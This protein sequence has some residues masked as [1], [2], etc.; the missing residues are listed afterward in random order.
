MC[1]KT[2]TYLTSRNTTGFSLILV[3]SPLRE[4]HALSPT[5]N[6][7]AKLI[8]CLII[9]PN[10]TVAESQLDNVSIITI[11]THT[12]CFIHMRNIHV[13]Y[14]YTYIHVAA[15]CRHTCTPYHACKSCTCT[16]EMVCVNHLTTTDIQSQFPIPCY[17][18]VGNLV[19]SLSTLLLS[20]DAIFSD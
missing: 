13:P 6:K 11:L 3:Y 18:L 17:L 12:H 19:S 7:F 14:I 16:A 4:K 8:I 20:I 5:R 10:I 15:Q 1:Y 2:Y 9:S